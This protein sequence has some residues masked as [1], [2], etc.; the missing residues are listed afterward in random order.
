MQAALDS[1]SIALAMDSEGIALAKQGEKKFIVPIVEKSLYQW[2]TIRV[3]T[4]LIIYQCFNKSTFVHQESQ[5]N[6]K[7]FLKR[8]SNCT[9]IRSP[10]AF[11]KAASTNTSFRTVTSH[12][13]L[14]NCEDAKIFNFDAGMQKQKL[15]IYCTLIWVPLYLSFWQCRT[16]PNKTGFTFFSWEKS[17]RIQNPNH[18]NPPSIWYNFQSRGVVTRT[19]IQLIKLAESACATYS[20]PR[21]SPPFKNPGWIPS[22]CAAF[23]SRNP[24]IHPRRPV[25]DA[26]N[27]P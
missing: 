16:I 12:P 7:K 18:N 8:A 22:T 10:I 6:K 11:G 13:L 27:P 25:Q 1:E 14:P 24:R 4:N 2:V 21:T 23:G 3:D 20:A 5:V 15:N 19:F 26:R 17:F 9:A